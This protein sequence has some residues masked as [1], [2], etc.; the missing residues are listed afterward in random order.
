MMLR[1]AI[2][3]SIVATT[4][5]FVNTYISVTEEILN[6]NSKIS[7]LDIQGWQGD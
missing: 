4:L 2:I 7:K 3:G 5:K 1:C 6:D